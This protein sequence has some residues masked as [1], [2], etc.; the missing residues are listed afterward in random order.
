MK[1]F[2][3]IAIALFASIFI[4]SCVGIS[5]GAFMHDTEVSELNTETTM[6]NFSG[7][8]VAGSMNVVLN[9][10]NKTS[11][12]VKGSDKDALDKVVIYVN[13]GNL[14]IKT[15]KKFLGFVGSIN[16]E[17]ITIYV[18]TPKIE[19]IELAGS[20]NITTDKPINA[21]NVNVELAGSGDIDILNAFT[22]NLLDVQIAGSGNATFEKVI[23]NSLKTSIA[24]SGNV[25]Y[26]NID[27]VSAAS[28]IAGSGNIT[29]KGKASKHT[30]DIVGSGNVGT[31]E[32][33]TP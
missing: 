9:Q 15:K 11:V 6:K 28:D 32:L 29:L 25:S 12:L 22:C 5:V 8:S 4:Y 33:K 16:L 21:D 18:T 20:G 2:K 10:G 7:I 27:V 26:N 31:T 17:D 19:S 13:D 1:I 14:Y 23:A 24:G 3:T 30:Q